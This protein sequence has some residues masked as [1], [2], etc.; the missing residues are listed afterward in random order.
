[1]VFTGIL[2]IRFYVEILRI[3]MCESGGGAYIWCR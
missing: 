2:V 3:V 1:M